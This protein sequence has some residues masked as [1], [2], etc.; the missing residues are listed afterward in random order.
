MFGKYKEISVYTFDSELK[1]LILHRSFDNSLET[2]KSLDCSRWT[3]SLYLDKNKLYKNNGF[4]LCLEGR[5]F[6][7]TQSRIQRF[8]NR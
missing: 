7:V 5:D 8:Y 3:L 1:G 4:Y 6:M 2:I